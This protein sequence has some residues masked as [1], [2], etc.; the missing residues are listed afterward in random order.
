MAGADRKFKGPHLSASLAEISD[1]VNRRGRLF[2]AEPPFRRRNRAGGARREL[3]AA[4]L[5]TASPSL[6][7]QVRAASGG[8]VRAVFDASAGRGLWRS[9]ALLRRGAS[10]IVFGLSSVAKPGPAGAIGTAGTLATLA[11]FKILPGKRTAVFAMGR[12]YHREPE[13]VRR[14]VQRTIEALAAGAIAPVVLVTQR[15]PSRHLKER[16]EVRYR[17]P[18]AL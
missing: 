13:R 1:R 4:I 17:S 8:G 7:D 6:V 2:A 18:F 15:P 3:G 14:L 16:H 12:M 9:R 5:D 10:L 11:L